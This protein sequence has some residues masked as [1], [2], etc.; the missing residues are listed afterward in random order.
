MICS[1]KQTYKAMKMLLSCDQD[2]TLVYYS[3][4]VERKDIMLKRNN[5][6]M[7]LFISF[8]II[9]LVFSFNMAFAQTIQGQGD[10]EEKVVHLDKEKGQDKR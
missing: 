3:V 4:I 5:R 9:S 6:L 1:H 10:S 2:V 8:V 7:K